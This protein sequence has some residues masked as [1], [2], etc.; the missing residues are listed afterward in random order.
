MQRTTRVIEPAATAGPDE[1]DLLS[2]FAPCCDA[3]LVAAE[4]SGSARV[5]FWHCPGCGL[6]LL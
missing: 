6:A 1:D 5:P 3:C 2:G 4:P